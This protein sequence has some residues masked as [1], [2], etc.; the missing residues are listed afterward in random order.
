MTAYALEPAWVL[1][2]DGIHRAVNTSYGVHINLDE[3]LP[4]P[5]PMALH[6]ADFCIE[7]NGRKVEKSWDE[8]LK[9]LKL[10]Q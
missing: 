4:S 8:M 2:P 7:F 9:L 3:G 6:Q 10:K 5:N 1:L